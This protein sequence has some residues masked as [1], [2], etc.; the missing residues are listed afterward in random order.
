[1]R[2]QGATYRAHNP[3]WSFKPLSGGGA[4]VH[5]GRF[6]PKSVAALYLALDPITAIKES[7]STLGK[8]IARGSPRPPPATRPLR[9]VSPSG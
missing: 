2:F 3:R 9:G 1:M 5:G 4:A 6:N 8:W 7:G